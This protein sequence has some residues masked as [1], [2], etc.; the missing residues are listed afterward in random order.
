M[1]PSRV[2]FSQRWTKW[3]SNRSQGCIQQR[4]A[5]DHAEEGTPS[6]FESS[7]WTLLSAAIINCRLDL[8]RHAGSASASFAGSKP[9]IAANSTWIHYEYICYSHVRQTIWLTCRNFL[10]H[11]LPRRCEPERRGTSSHLNC[12]FICADSEWPYTSQA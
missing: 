3:K 6:S 4:S 12:I 2:M 11:H 1:P 8:F 5:E 9:Y 7:S 10:P